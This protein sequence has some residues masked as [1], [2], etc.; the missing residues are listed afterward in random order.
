M[1][2]LRLLIAAALLSAGSARAADR[3]LVIDKF[4]A[5]VQVRVDGSIDVVE[6]ITPTFTG[7][8]NGIY[9]TIPI[10]YR[11]PQGLNY[12][13]RLEIEDVTDGSGASLRY[14]SSRVRHYRK[15]KIWVPGAQDATRTV[16]IHYRVENAL[17]FFDE[18]DELYW[19]ITGDEWDVPIRAA[20]ALIVLPEG[21]SGIRA[22]AFRGEY[23]IDC[24]KRGHGRRHLRARVHVRPRASRG[25]HGCRRLEPRC[26]A[27]ADRC[28]PHRLDGLQ[29]LAA[30]ASPPRLRRHV[31]A[32]ALTRPGS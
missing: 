15:L 19:N 5:T 25:A 28:G 3:T 12:T 20:T 27:A 22:T 13:L 16:R 30:H 31:H 17:R 32:L 6:T 21:V 14:E 11:T 24:T 23:R 9:R 8:W 29:Q 1:R 2:A 26:G 7:A 18:H 10:E 4:D